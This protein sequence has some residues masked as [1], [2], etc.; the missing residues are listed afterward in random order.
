MKGRQPKRLAAKFSIVLLV[1][2]SSLMTASQSRASSASAGT[3][4]WIIALQN[5]V[6]FSQSGT[7]GAAPA[8][9]T[10]PQWVIDVTT[11]GGQT[12]AAMLLSAYL[13]G[14]PV[15][16]AGTSTCSL[17]PNSE[18]VAYVSLSQ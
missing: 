9:A 13:A 4:T 18:T 6:L 15:A 3:V 14:K 8:C 16:V 11:P 5:V 7:R 17:T 2:A 10:D 12:M 1:A